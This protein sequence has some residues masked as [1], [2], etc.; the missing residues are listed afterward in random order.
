[1]GG[2]VMAM[3]QLTQGLSVVVDE[4]DLP[5]LT[6][7]KWWATY[8][9]K[10][11]SKTYTYA[12]G[13]VNGKVIRMHRYIMGL[14]PSNSLVVDHIDGN[15]LNNTRA[16][17]RVCSLRENGL[18]SAKKFESASRYKGVQKW[19]KSWA[20]AIK[21]DG[22]KVHLGCFDNEVMAAVAYNK[23]AAEHYGEFARLNPI[24]HEQ[25]ISVL[26]EQKEKIG[27]EIEML[28][29]MELEQQ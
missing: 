22:K 24:Y 29:A 8:V 16:N 15:T 7:H 20:A 18:N 28:C 9:R 2:L 5:L 14:E 17:L 21:L 27:R 13:S 3:I 12:A 26:L 6:A 23:A 10:P 1:M 25:A 19:R 11:N 4:A